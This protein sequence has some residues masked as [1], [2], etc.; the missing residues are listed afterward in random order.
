MSSTVVTEPPP[1]ALNVFVERAWRGT[2][3]DVAD[4]GVVLVSG[5]EAARAVGWAA[6]GSGTSRPTS[7]ARTG[8]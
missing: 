1:Q 8:R 6:Q 3:L 7:T 4:W 2:G 5:G